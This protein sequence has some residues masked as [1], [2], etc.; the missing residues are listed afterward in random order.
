MHDS[1]KNNVVY[2]S[3]DMIIWFDVTDV[4]LQPEQTFS[5]DSDYI[6]LDDHIIDLSQICL[7]DHEQ[8]F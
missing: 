6:H 4:N 3:N 8:W 1:D 2:W 7:G 5:S